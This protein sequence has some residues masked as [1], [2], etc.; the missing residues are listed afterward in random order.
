MSHQESGLEV[1][2]A[3]V[4]GGSKDV[5]HPTGGCLW[6]D[7]GHESE[8]VPLGCGATQEELGL[9]EPKP[10]GGAS[11]PEFGQLEEARSLPWVRGDSQLGSSVVLVH[12][13][14]NCA[15]LCEEKSAK[16]SSWGHQMLT[17]S[18]LVL[19]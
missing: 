19:D 1:V 4:A 8:A 14:V 11:C 9:S 3:V 18:W 15:K 12:A 6:Q 10:G 17:Q 5:G 16:R 2:V 7:S 13:H